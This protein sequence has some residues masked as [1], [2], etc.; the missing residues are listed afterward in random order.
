MYKAALHVSAYLGRTH[1]AECL[2]LPLG[3]S[4]KRC[5]YSECKGPSS[6]QDQT[7][8]AGTLNT[9]CQHGWGQPQIQEGN[10]RQAEDLQPLFAISTKV[11]SLEKVAIHGG[12]LSG[13]GS[14]TTDVDAQA[15]AVR[16]R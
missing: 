7:S 3:T 8:L 6:R 14:V 12:T 10:L 2:R 5:P 15:D 16:Q 4:G 11:P 13:H 1:T 9:Y